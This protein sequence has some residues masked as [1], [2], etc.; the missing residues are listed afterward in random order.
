MDGWLDG[1]ECGVG[2]EEKGDEFRVTLTQESL[3]A[4]SKVDPGLN[5]P[6]SPHLSGILEEAGL[7]PPGPWRTQGRVWVSPEASAWV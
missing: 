4:A 2:N 7:A 5:A 3:G 6:N 1:W